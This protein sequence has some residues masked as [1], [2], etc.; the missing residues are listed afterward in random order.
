MKSWRKTKK[1]FSLV[2]SLMSYSSVPALVN[3]SLS[4]VPM[5]LIG[6]GGFGKVY[7]EHYPLDDHV[8]AVKRVLLTHETAGNT[9][10]EVRVLSGLDHEHIV[11]YYHSWLESVSSPTESG[12]IMGT[13][14]SESISSL[15][16]SSSSGAGEEEGEEQIQESTNSL[17][18]FFLCIRMQFCESTLYRYLRENNQRVFPRKDDLRFIREMIS[19]VRYL[20]A[21]GILHRDLKPENMLLYNNSIKISDFGLAKILFGRGGGSDSSGETTPLA[22]K[23]SSMYLG[24]P[25][26]A[27]PEQYR[28]EEEKEGE[29]ETPLGMEA[30]I[31]SLCVIFFEMS[32]SFTT[33]M[34]RI[35]RIQSFRSGQMTGVIHPLLQ[36][37][38]GPPGERPSLDDLEAVLSTAT[39]IKESRDNM[40]GYKTGNEE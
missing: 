32:I 16:S 26:Y 15:A 24:T 10:R 14:S 25:L 37:A 17:P 22:C 33:E 20:H 4:T 38:M 13:L 18:R 2:S 29:K 1:V 12:V 3:N 7:R 5:T 11:R 6:K 9:L 21:Q 8:Y 19:G 36:K 30:D 23:P 31:Y 35:L 40:P 34:E 39:G 27:P 28:R